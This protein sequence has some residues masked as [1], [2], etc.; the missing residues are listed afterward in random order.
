MA[1]IERHPQVED[2]ILSFTLPELRRRGGAAD[3]IEAGHLVLIDDFRLDFEFEAMSQLARSVDSV[4]D[5][6]IRRKLKKLTT[7]QFF[8][9]EPPVRSRGRLVFSDRVRQAIYDIICHGDEATYKRAAKALRSAHEKMLNIFSTAFP[10]YEAFRF[11]PSLRITQ[12]LFENLHWDNHSIDD[13]FHQARVFANLDTR[14]RIWHVSH[15]FTEFMRAHYAELDLGRFRD[16]DPNDMLQFIHS[17]VLGGFDAWWR[18]TLPRHRIAFDPGEV[19]LGESRLVSHQIYYGEC[20]MVYMWF[21]EVGKMVDPNRRFNER[22]AAI[23]AEYQEASD[24]KMSA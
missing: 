24:T 17:E 23:H 6:A 5:V 18:D 20:A 3:L 7:T 12:T 22:V 21:I 13:D 19:W 1:T 14:P 16:R 2:Y 9:G 11:I 8:E 10:N 4:D 15:R